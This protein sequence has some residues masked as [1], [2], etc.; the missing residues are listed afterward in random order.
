MLKFELN[1][2]SNNNWRLGYASYATVSDYDYYWLT[3]CDDEWVLLGESNIS[4]VIK[5]QERQLSEV[6]AARHTVEQHLKETEA[7]TLVFDLAAESLRAAAETSSLKNLFEENPKIVEW[8]TR[9]DE[10]SYQIWKD[11]VNEEK[12]GWISH[13]Y[14]IDDPNIYTLG[15]FERVLNEYDQIISEINESLAA[16]KEIYAQAVFPYSDE[17]EIPPL[18]PRLRPS[19]HF[20]KGNMI[21]G[22]TKSHRSYKLWSPCL[23]VLMFADGKGKIATSSGYLKRDYIVE[24]PEIMTVDEARYYYEHDEYR[25][26][27][28]DRTGCDDRKFHEILKSLDERE[29]FKYLAPLS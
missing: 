2:T 12:N 18:L 11:W 27:L 5:A 7:I 9:A 1:H 10:L 17:S 13:V 28:A 26:F 21:I 6:K 20:K 23:D 29:I 15:S 14:C 24:S 25:H 8:E 16:L 3:L 19:N 4:T 22:W